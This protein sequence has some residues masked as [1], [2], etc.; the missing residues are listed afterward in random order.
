VL[1]LFL[2]LL[3]TFM[4]LTVFLWMGAYFFQGY[5]YTEP[6]P[7]LFWQAPIAAFLLTFGFAIWALSLALG[8]RG[9]PTNR[10]IDTILRFS[11]RDE[12]LDRP[13]PRIWAV[14]RDRSKKDEIKE[15]ESIPYVAARDDQGKFYYRQDSA[16][17]KRPWQPQDVIAIDV[18]KVDGSKMRFNLVKTEAG[19][20]RQF[21]SA[22]G[23]VIQEFETGPTGIPVKFFYGR[24]IWNL[25]FNFGHL[26]GWFIVLW[27]VLRFQWL[28]ALGLGFVMWLMF[29]IIIVPMLLGY[30][31]EV[32]ASRNRTR[33]AMILH[34]IERG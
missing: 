18:E 26:F 34:G 2:V 15:G 28:H 3:L 11:P 8:E 9:S 17:I 5:I 32:A 7:G 1:G 27:V 22:D 4:S 33:A 14:K 6:S 25:I 10:P 29:T 19:Q 16:S 30:A 23:W 12:M 24:L 31:G 21:A 20:Y 13:A